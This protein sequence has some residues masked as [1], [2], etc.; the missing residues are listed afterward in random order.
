MARRHVAAL[1]KSAACRPRAVGHPGRQDPN[2][3]WAGPRGPAVGG[4]GYAV[5]HPAIRM[6]LRFFGVC[7]QDGR[8]APGQ[9]PGQDA[10]K[11]W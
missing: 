11:H 10:V 7:Y 3:G 5:G 6:S 8:W 2:A 9:G 4:G 1:P